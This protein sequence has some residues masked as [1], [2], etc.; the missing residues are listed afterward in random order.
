MVPV[1]LSG[2]ERFGFVALLVTEMDPLA[3]P[4]TLGAKVIV[5]TLVA[6]TANVNGV[7]IEA[8]N[9]LPEMLTLETVSDAVPV[10][11]SVTV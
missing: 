8:E 4:A 2:M 1:P 3:A 10:F 6:P 5:R 11:L 9:P 7:D